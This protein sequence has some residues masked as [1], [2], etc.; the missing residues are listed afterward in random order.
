MKN[1]TYLIKAPH[2][3][4]ALWRQ[5]AQRRGITLA[6]LIRTA[7]NKEIQGSVHLQQLDWSEDE[8]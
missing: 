1:D 2:G 6:Q 3:M 5:E 8:R 7:V 4:L